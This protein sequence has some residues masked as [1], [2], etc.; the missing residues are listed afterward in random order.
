[1]E[2][3]KPN[4]KGLFY[5]S[6][7]LPKNK[8]FYIQKK[9]RAILLLRIGEKFLEKSVAEH[10]S[11]SCIKV[12]Y[13]ANSRYLHRGVCCPSPVLDIFVKNA[14]R[15]KILLRPTERSNI[16]NRYVYDVSGR[17]VFIDN[18]LDGKMVSSEYLL[19]YENIVY[20]ITIGMS[21]QIV[22]ISEEQYSNSRIESYSCAYYSPVG[23]N[24]RCYHMDSENYRYD[25][26]GLAYWDYYQIFFE[27]EQAG[28]DGF[29]QHNRYRFEREGGLLKAYTRVNIDGTTIDGSV[30]NEIKVKR[31][32]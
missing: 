12:E 28:V 8:S 1:M 15:G 19:Y 21:G 5:H 29:I 26:Y 32:A 11:I 30:I 16:T 17:L 13:G 9:D 4:T 20:G 27:W 6:K 18:Y 23:E 7:T 14:K 10:R 22:C 2:R 24:V 25:E 3:N 31:K